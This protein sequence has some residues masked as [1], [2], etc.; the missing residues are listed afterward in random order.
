MS[1]SMSEVMTL[2]YGWKQSNILVHGEVNYYLIEAISSPVVLTVQKCVECHLRIGY[3]NDLE[4]IVAEE[5]E[6]RVFKK[7]ISP[8]ENYLFVKVTSNNYAF[9]SI[10]VQTEDEKES[11]VI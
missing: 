1:A 3:G 10:V 7:E 2:P 5:I 8:E 4:S 6:E 11:V 9:Y